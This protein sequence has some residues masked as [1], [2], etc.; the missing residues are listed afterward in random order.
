MR[1]RESINTRTVGEKMSEYSRHTS[2]M[3]CCRLAD[4]EM[5][6]SI[7]MLSMCAG[8]EAKVLISTGAKSD[9]SV[10]SCLLE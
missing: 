3:R 6:M 10:S 8:D 9:A 2:R 5:L 1:G 4:P 7:S